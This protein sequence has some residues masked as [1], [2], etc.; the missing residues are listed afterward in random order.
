[1]RCVSDSLIYVNKV[2]LK[3]KIIRRGWACQLFAFNPGVRT[4]GTG[5]KMV[6]VSLSAWVLGTNPGP[7]ARAGHALNH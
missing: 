1:L 4:P 7:S 2:Y 5:I 6:V 3:L